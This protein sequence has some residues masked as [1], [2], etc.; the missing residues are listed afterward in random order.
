MYKAKNGFTL[1]DSK[2]PDGWTIKTPQDI[3]TALLSFPAFETVDSGY[4]W[5]AI[6]QAADSRKEYENI[7]DFAKYLTE[8][9][10]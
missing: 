10:I 6:D 8:N 2:T 3:V 1:N 5:E 9:Y 4:I 7:E